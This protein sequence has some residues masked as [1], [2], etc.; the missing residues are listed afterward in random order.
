MY[1][2]FYKTGIAGEIGSELLS[3]KSFK[4]LKGAEKWASQKLAL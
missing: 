3:A 2:Q 4:T 1:T